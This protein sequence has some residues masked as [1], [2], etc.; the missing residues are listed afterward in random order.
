MKRQDFWQSGEIACCFLVA[1]VLLLPV[2][3]LSASTEPGEKIRVFVSILPYAYFVER[4][5]GEHMEIEVMVGPGQS[6]ATY[7]ASSRQMV[8]LSRS[9][10]YF[11]AGV[12]FEKRLLKKISGAS[13]IL[14]IVNPQEGLKLKPM[15]VPESHAEH[16][17]GDTDPHIWLDPIAV[18]TIAKNIADEL[19]RHR[20]ENA[21]EFK[22]NSELFSADLERVHNRISEI[23]SPFRGRKFLVFHPILGYFADRYGLEQVTVEIEGKEPTARQLAGLIEKAKRDSIGVIFVQPQFSTKSAEAIADVT[24]G[25]VVEVDALERDYLNNLEK[26]ALRLAEG[27]KGDE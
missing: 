5:G 18:K 25:E 16:H 17:G 1:L 4:V 11:R 24:G 12:P 3:I 7:E 21:A 14:N 9:D 26:I 2:S 10:V 22:A 19:K 23:L 8:L 20:P 6:P 15:A 27:F 13:L